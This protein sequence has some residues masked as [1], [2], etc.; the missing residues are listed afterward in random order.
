MVIMYGLDWSDSDA[1]EHVDAEGVMCK[2][3]GLEDGDKRGTGWLLA[4]GLSTKAVLTEF[5]HVRLEP[6][7][8]HNFQKGGL[9]VDVA[10]VMVVRGQS[11][12][13]L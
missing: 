2:Y 7:W 10:A 13:I 12:G 9:S 8:R 5:E 6:G 3:D 1:G 4:M 11:S